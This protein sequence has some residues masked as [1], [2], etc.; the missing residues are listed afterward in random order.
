MPGLW[1]DSP[2][3]VSEKLEEMPSVLVTTQEKMPLSSRE[4]LLKMALDLN[5]RTL[6]W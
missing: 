4:R 2:F 6:G 5:M 3:S 1:V